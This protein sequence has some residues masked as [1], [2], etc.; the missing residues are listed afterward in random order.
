M[1]EFAGNDHEEKN[2]PAI[3]ALGAA[4][5][6]DQGTAAFRRVVDDDEELAAVALFEAL[7]DRDH[8]RMLPLGSADAKRVPVP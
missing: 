6:V 2:E 4:R 7:A 8:R 1:L 3:G 5:G